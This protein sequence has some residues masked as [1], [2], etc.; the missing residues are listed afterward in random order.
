MATTVHIPAALL[1]RI[2]ARAKARGMSRNR[3]IVEALD[4]SLA[5]DDDWS[6]EFVDALAGMSA[7]A[8][9]SRAADQ[10][11]ASISRTRRSRRKPPF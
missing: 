6:P 10:M 4:R 1:R 8:A 11:L 5:E 7:D 3:L 2:D 9:V